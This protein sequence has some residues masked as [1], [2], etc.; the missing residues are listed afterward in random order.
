MTNETIVPSGVISFTEDLAAMRL[1]AK[2]YIVHGRLLRDLKLQNVP[3]ISFSSGTF[4]GGN[5]NYPIVQSS[6]WKSLNEHQ[7]I[8]KLHS[9]WLMLILLIL[10]QA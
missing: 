4:R 5:C 10:Y 6:A 9:S 8:L 7:Q 1:V 2:E 3:M